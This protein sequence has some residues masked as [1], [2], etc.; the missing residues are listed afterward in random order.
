MWEQG[1]CL[2]CV[3]DKMPSQKIKTLKS[4]ILTLKTKPQNPNPK[5]QILKPQTT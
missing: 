2:E 4:Q 5:K 1:K 3:I